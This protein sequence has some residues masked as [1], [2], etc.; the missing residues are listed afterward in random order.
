MLNVTALSKQLI[1]TISN[2]SLEAIAR[3]LNTIKV[4]DYL[5]VTMKSYIQHWTL[6]FESENE[7]KTTRITANVPQGSIL[8]MTLWNSMY[9]EVLK[10]NL[11]MKLS[12]VV[13]QTWDSIKVLATVDV[14]DI[15]EAY[16]RKVRPVWYF[17]KINIVLFVM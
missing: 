2:V 9:D 4:P 14:L 16:S 5:C 8:C 1:S 10:P 3:A 7:Q 6:V 12:V 13:E 11:P 17:F 15:F